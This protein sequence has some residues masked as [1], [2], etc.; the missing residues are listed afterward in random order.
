MINTWNESLLHEELKS[1]FCGENG[2]TEVPL[3]GS[4]CDAIRDDGSVVEIQTAHLGKLKK[5][6]EKLLAEH[7]VN[8]VY[9]VARNTVIETFSEDN[10]LV[11]RRKSPKH[12]TV[13]QIFSELTGLWNLIGHPNLTLTVVHADVLELRIAD[14]TGSWRRKGVRIL[15]RKLLKMYETDEFRTKEDYARLLSPNLPEPFT[16][17]DLKKSGAGNYAGKMAWVL[18]KTKII[19]FEGRD[20]RAFTYRR[21][22]LHQRR[23]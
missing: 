14:G 20:G 22:S 15:D 16:V 19:N 1:Y 5:K 11:S 3:E 23:D 4:I 8:L 12:G 13:F 7:K 17:S 18:C 21:N 2:H 9:P 6:L 10:S